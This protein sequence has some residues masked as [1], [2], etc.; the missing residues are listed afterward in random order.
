MAAGFLGALARLG[1]WVTR[2]AVGVGASREDDKHLG[3]TLK[4][5][6]LGVGGAE[7]GEAGQRDLERGG[8]GSDRRA[9]WGIAAAATAITAGKSLHAGEERL[10]KNDTSLRI[11]FFSLPIVTGSDEVEVEGRGRTKGVGGE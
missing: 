9:P 8:G 6:H 7:G 4:A 2:A 3:K 1:Q 5:F 10:R 11:P